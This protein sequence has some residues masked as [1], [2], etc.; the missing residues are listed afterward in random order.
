[1]RRPG[2]LVTAPLVG[3][4]MP[5]S[6]RARLVLPAPFGPMMVT[7]S[8]ERMPMSTCSRMT[9]PPSDRLRPCPVISSMPAGCAAG[10]GA[11]KGRTVERVMRASRR[12]APGRLAVGAGALNFE[13]RLAH[14]KSGRT[15]DGVDRPRCRRR[16]GFGDAS[17]GLPGQHQHRTL[18]AM[19]GE[20]GEECFAAFQAMHQPRSQENVD[21]PIYGNRRET[22][23]L[24]MQ[25]IDD[26]V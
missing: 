19:L 25:L 4:R 13:D 21:H 15:G 6:M 8:P 18:V 9:R 3:R 2:R 5:S 23:A 14:V 12:L 17:A 16:H 1:M 26:L 10:A 20:A 24:A 22:P 7:I 11:L